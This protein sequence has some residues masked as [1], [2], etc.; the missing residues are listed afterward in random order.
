MKI[1]SDRIVRE[2]ETRE[3]TG[4]SRTTRWRLEQDDKFP[5]R[6]AIS[7]N[8][9]GWRLSEIIAWIEARKATANG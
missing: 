6:L 3:I 1:A 8:A 4:L 5:K 9:I 2:A 7:P